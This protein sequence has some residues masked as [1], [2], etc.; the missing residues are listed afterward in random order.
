MTDGA[1]TPPLMLPAP[2]DVSEADASGKFTVTLSGFSRLGQE[3]WRSEP[4]TVGN[5]KWRASGA[6]LR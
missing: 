1:A 4:F 5:Y 3:K 6:G 2:A